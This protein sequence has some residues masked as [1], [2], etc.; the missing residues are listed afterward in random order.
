MIEELK[1]FIEVV[2]HKNFTKASEIVNLSQPTVSQH[3]KR[4][5][6]YFDVLLIERSSKNKKITITPEGEILY[7]RGKEIIKALDDTKLEILQAQRTIC[8]KLKIGATLTVGEHFLPPFLKQFSAEYP[9]LK[10]EV[11]IENTA[12]ICEKVKDLEVDIG[13][14]EGLDPH[15]SFKREYFYVDH[16][17][18]VV[19][20]DSELL[21]KPHLSVEDLQNQV[22]IT[23]EEGSGT[24][25]Y[26]DLFL[27][28]NN[29]SPK[30]IMIFSSNYA[31]KEAV[32][33][34]LGI[35]LISEF[36]VR[37]SAHDHELYI[38]SL[39]KDYT[40]KFSYIVSKDRKI[41]APVYRLI[42]RLKTYKP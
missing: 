10:L 35:T 30:D 41:T 28:M 36:V 33:E 3:V 20:K 29:I 37:H 31:V 14:I 13:L 39:G 34:G 24:R 2:K 21:K 17:V 23:R 32:K 25:E 27:N 19:S 26:L 38:L 22:W 9:E 15:Y 5:E 40:R 12:S 42:Q 16:M 8:R 11:I 6:S 1:T 7:E 18:L 4:L